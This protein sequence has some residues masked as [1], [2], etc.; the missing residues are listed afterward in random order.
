MKKAGIVVAF[1]LFTFGVGTMEGAAQQ[2]ADMPYDLH[3]IDM[4]VMHH[5]DGIEM[6]QIAQTRAVNTKIKAFAA[7]LPLTNKRID[8][9]GIKMRRT[10]AFTALLVLVFVSAGCGTTQNTNNTNATVTASPSPAAS[11]ANANANVH[12]NMNASEHA[13]MNMNANRNRNANAS[14]TP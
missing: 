14:P 13:N 2:M 8:T 4:T 3:Y 11:A 12:G 1:V 6:A 7:K 5:Q 9:G 10:T